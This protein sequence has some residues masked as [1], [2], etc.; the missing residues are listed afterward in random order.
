MTLTMNAWV[1]FPAN[2]RRGKLYTTKVNEIQFASS[3]K[4]TVDRGSITLPRNLKFFDKTPVTDL[5]KRGDEI[6]V[7]MGYDFDVVEEFRGYITRVS[8]GFP[9][10]LEFEDEMYHI[11]RLPANFSVPSITLAQLF[12]RLTPDYPKDILEGVSMGAVRFSQ[13]QVGPVIDKIQQ[14][15]GLYTFMRKGVLTCG[16]YYV[17]ELETVAFDLE[18]DCVSNGLNYFLKDEIS[19]LIKAVSTLSNGQKIEANPVGDRL[20]NERVLTF[21]NIQ[22]KSEL[23]RLAR[24]EYEKYK[25]D[26]FEGSFT[27]FGTPSVQHGMKCHITSTLYPER[28]GVYYIESVVKTFNSSGYRQEI[29][30]GDKVI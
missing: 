15:W 14:D 13:T 25:Q 22:N 11:R 16:K 21:Y 10:V 17:N 7:Y 20:G 9:I 29:T 19:I 6:V 26:K 1:E 28:Q 23:E 30:L 8:S 3:F 4:E 18:R 2:D 12:D 5:F 27:A 24:L